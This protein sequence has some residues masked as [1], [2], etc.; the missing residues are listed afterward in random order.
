MDVSREAR[1]R[2]HARYR[3]GV[4]GPGHRPSGAK[5]QEILAEPITSGATSCPEGRRV[6]ARRGN[7]IADPRQ[8]AEAPEGYPGPL[9]SGGSV[10]LG[11][12]W[13]SRSGGERLFT[14]EAETSGLGRGGGPL[15]VALSS[16]VAVAAVRGGTN[17]TDLLYGTACAD[18]ICALADGDALV[19]F[20]GN[21]R[22][23]GGPGNDIS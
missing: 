16:A 10:F 19:G 2:P 15:L 5:V 13:D 6:R 1:W 11:V 21:D 7:A 9:V 4:P 14:Q 18:T 8:R 22:I 23:Y 20:W 17:E 3:F 12:R